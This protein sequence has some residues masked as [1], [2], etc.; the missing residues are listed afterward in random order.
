MEPI[1][2]IAIVGIIALIGIGIFYSRK[3][4]PS[5]S[6]SIKRASTKTASSKVK[7]RE[8]EEPV[9]ASATYDTRNILQLR[10]SSGGCLSIPDANNESDPTIQKCN[11][12]D[13]KQRWLYDPNKTQLQS[14]LGSCLAA[15]SDGSVVGWVCEPNKKDQ[16]WKYSG[17]DG[18]FKNPSSGTCLRAESD[19]ND[20]KIEAVAC[21]REPNQRWNAKKVAF[22]GS[23][24]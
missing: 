13:S 18:S 1:V 3:S 20:S 23:L 17:T 5:P 24:Y 2:I 15:R 6:S 19:E 12:A 7:T 4:S 16:R 14:V 11:S 22:L 10:A 21:E 9:D 8:E